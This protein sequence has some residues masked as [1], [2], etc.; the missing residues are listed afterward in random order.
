MNAL[1]ACLAG[2]PCTDKFAQRSKW[3]LAEYDKL[4]MSRS[5]AT[6]QLLETEDKLSSKNDT[7]ALLRKMNSIL[8]TKIEKTLRQL[9]QERRINSSLR[10]EITRDEDTIFGLKR[11]VCAGSAVA[12]HG[13]VQ[14]FI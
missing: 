13:Q 1:E 2:C 9:A 11:Q 14:T 6:S 5:Q 8:S 4:E 3:I 10:A 12:W 7:I